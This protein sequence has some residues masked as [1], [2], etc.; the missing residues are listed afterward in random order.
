[1]VS[2]VAKTTEL[3][4]RSLESLT[5]RALGA[6]HPLK[7][8][9]SEGVRVLAFGCESKQTALDEVVSPTFASAAGP[10]ASSLHCKEKYFGRT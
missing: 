2:L 6:A 10:G 9:K 7:P 4:M 5:V 8:G 3:L 1:M